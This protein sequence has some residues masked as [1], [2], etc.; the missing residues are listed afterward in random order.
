MNNLIEQITNNHQNSYK[1]TSSKDIVFTKVV[2][3]PRKDLFVIMSD[4][5]R[6]PVIMPKNVISSNIINKTSDIIYSLEV[7]EESFVRTKLLVKHELVPYEKHS[8]EVIE[9]EAKNSIIILQFDDYDSKT[10]ITADVRLRAEGP[11]AI[12][13]ELLTES[14]IQSAM[15]TMIDTFTD[16]LTNEKN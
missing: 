9:G 6:Y 15:S 10:K 5:E 12:L 4:I 7:V 2:D 1:I 13:L 16:F 3:V 11:V 8:F 14:N